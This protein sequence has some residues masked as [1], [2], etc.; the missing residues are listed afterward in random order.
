MLFSKNHLGSLKKNWTP[1]HSPNQ[2]NQHLWTWH[3]TIGIFKVPSDSNENQRLK[4]TD[5]GEDANRE[6]KEARSLSCVQG[7]S[8]IGLQRQKV[9]AKGIASFA[10]P[11]TWFLLWLTSW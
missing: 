6:E 7:W 8:V 4:T 5:K 9:K 2:L 3:P 1:G 11:R 10:V